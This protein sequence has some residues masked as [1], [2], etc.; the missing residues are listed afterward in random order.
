MQD[1]GQSSRPLL[2]SPLGWET[3]AHNQSIHPSCHKISMS[4]WYPVCLHE[5]CSSVPLSIAF[6]TRKSLCPFFGNTMSRSPSCPSSCML[7]CQSV[8]FFLYLLILWLCVLL[9]FCIVL[10]PSVFLPPLFGCSSVLPS[11]EF[12]FLVVRLWLCPSVPPSVC[13]FAYLTVRTS[14]FNMRNKLRV[15]LTGCNKN[16]KEW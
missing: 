9:S 8:S 2:S 4:L 10:S 11:L 6:S 13:P 5:I 12:V 3:T 7:L 16:S 1:K 14:C 15:T